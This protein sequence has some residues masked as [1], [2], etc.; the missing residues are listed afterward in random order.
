MGLADLD[1]GKKGIKNMDDRKISKKNKTR[2]IICDPE[3]EY[4]YLTKNL[5]GE[6]IDIGN[7]SEGRINPF[8]IYQVL[9]EDGGKSN[10]LITFNTHLKV[11]HLLC[12]LL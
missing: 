12:F 6:V 10:S 11:F 2:V 5:K 1:L 7:A 8:H 3:A 4:L 9:S